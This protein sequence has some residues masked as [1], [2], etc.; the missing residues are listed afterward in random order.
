[1][2]APVTL[3]KEAISGRLA[4]ALMNS[5]PTQGHVYQRFWG[6]LLSTVVFWPPFS[7]AQVA[8]DQ[9]LTPKSLPCLSEPCQPNEL[10]KYQFETVV[11]FH[12]R[13]G[14]H[15]KVGLVQASDGF[16]YGSTYEGGQ[17]NQGTLFRLTPQGELT[18]LIHFNGQNGAYPLSALMQ[19][20]DGNLYGTT[21]QG[22][23][24]NQG[25]LFRL[26]LSG[27][28]T[29]L[30]HFYG[31]RG[32][33]PS[34]ALVEGPEQTLYGTT[35]KGGNLG[36]CA[37]GCGTI[38][39]I[40]LKGRLSPR[41]E[42]NGLNGALPQSGLTLDH[43]GQLWG[44]TL[45]GGP[46]N[47][48][49]VFRLNPKG[50]FK[51]VVTFNVRN[52]AQPSGRLLQGEDRNYYLY[53]VTRTGGN[54]GQGTLFRLKP[55]G[56]LAP[57]YHFDGKPGANPEGELTLGADGKLYGTT[58]NG[59][60]NQ[61]GLVFQ[62]S[63][64]GQLQVLKVFRQVEGANPKGALVFAKNG[65]LYGITEQGGRYNSGTIYRLKAE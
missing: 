28:L 24:R 42:F 22:G 55:S 41:L 11:H 6:A 44:T 54:N 49:V 39:S 21:L 59:A 29:T 40:G 48:G 2:V 56:Q 36:R 45:R 63:T 10:G 37:Q 1:M 43:E 65:F 26:T 5:K 46:N 35:Q 32:V 27:A 15:P 47:L 3:K 9:S 51:R 23:Q 18:T 52:G 50:G 64:L 30:V 62:T 34:G 53:G 14:S 60:P 38:F 17:Y 61:P 4:V 58:T 7:M 33:Y 13:L 20:S 25:T 57:L 8:P 31:H 12:R 19:A 16:F